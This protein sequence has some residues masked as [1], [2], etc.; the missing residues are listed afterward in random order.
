M[1]IS[2][3]LLHGKV[4]MSIELNTLQII[5]T[6]ITLTIT[7]LLSYEFGKYKGFM[8]GIERSKKIFNVKE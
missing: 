4:N 5:T 7:T 6:V 2:R 3:L 1:G 8:E